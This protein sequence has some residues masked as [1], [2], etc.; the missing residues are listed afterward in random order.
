MLNDKIKVYK[1]LWT[2]DLK[3]GQSIVVSQITEYS[4]YAVVSSIYPMPLFGIRWG[5]SIMIFGADCNA[6]TTIRIAAAKMS[7]SQT[8]VTLTK[9]KLQQISTGEMV[10]FN[11]NHIYG[12]S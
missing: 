4:V 5:T 6:Q 3:P 2:G 10:D 7:I 8:K 11:I 12:I 1:E 9:S